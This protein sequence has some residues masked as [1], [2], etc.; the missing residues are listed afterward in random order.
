MPD[1]NKDIQLQ[2]SNGEGIYLFCFARAHVLPVLELTGLD[3]RYPLRQWRFNDIMAVLSRVS[4]NE[5]CGPSA[6]LKM[7]DLSWLGPRACRHEEVVEQVQRCS[8]VLPARFG[9]IFSSL[10]S[11]LRLLEMHH[12]TIS[13]FLDWV[14]DKEEWAVKVLVDRERA[15]QRFLSKILASE[16]ERLASLTPGAQY[17][18]KKRTTGVADNELAH[19]LRGACKAIWR[20]LYRHASSFRECKVL[21]REATGVNM[22]MVMNW[23]FLVARHS[24]ADFKARADR[25]AGEYE[26]QGLALVLS[27]PWPPYSFCPPLKME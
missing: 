12:G 9:T 22:D 3:D 7:R 1:D 27:G 24:V 2:S 21:S 5:F 13:Q 23:A 25:A 15:K 4:L 26:R 11:L 16:E 14:A 19:W 10:E 20:D 17:F 6:E 18:E 8:P